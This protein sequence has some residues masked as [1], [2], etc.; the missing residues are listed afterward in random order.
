MNY[1][2]L[3]PASLRIEISSNNLSESPQSLRREQF[4]P[5]ITADDKSTILQHCSRLKAENVR[6][7]HLRIF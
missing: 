3:R 6:I 4:K 1:Q 5:T 2:I 7:S